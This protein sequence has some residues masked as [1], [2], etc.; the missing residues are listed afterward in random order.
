M[1]V[2]ER[3][4]SFLLGLPFHPVTMAETMAICCDMVA[5]RQPRYVITANVDFVAQAYRNP[6]LRTILQ[7]ADL[8]VCDGMPLVWLSRMFKPAL[9]ERVAGSDLVFQLFEQA[10]QHGWR[11]FFLGSDAATLEI[12]RGVLAQRYPRMRVADCF[13]PPFGPVD[14]WPNEAILQRIE[15]AQPDLLLIAVGCPKQEYWI[16]QFAKSSGVPL[17]IGIGASLDF[18]AGSQRRAPR[19]MQKTGMEWLW[20]MGTDPMRLAKRYAKDFY[21]L[22]YLSWVQWRLTR[23]ERGSAARPDGAALRSAE[24][25]R[26]PA[27][28]DYAHLE[29]IPVPEVKRGQTV[30]DLS[31]VTFM[32]SS[33]IG[34][35]VH[36]AREAR[37]V[38]VTLTLRAP[39]PVVTRLLDAMKL[40][41]LFAYEPSADRIRVLLSAGMIQKGESG[42]GRYVVELANR[43]AADPRVDLHVAGLHSDRHL[44]PAIADAAWHTI[45]AAFGGGWRNLLWHQFQLRRLLRAVGADVYH[46]PSYRRVMAACPVAQIA[47]VHDCAPFRLRD[48]YGL[49]RGL[50]GRQLVPRLV[51]RCASVITVSQFTAEDLQ[52]F[53]GLPAERISVIANGIDPEHLYP[54]DAGQ[55]AAFRKAQQLPESYFLYISRLEHPGKNHVRLLEA[56]DAYRKRGG[57]AVALVLGGADWH[58]AEVI[59]QRVAASPW[60]ADIHLVGFIKEVD[61]PL[62]YG[63]AHAMVFPSLMEGFGLPVVEAMACGVPVACSDRGSLPEVAGGA[64]LLFDPESITAMAAVMEQL[65]GLTEAQRHRRCADGLANAG[66]FHWSHAAELTASAYCRL[67]KPLMSR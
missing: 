30:L 14:Q 16:D 27:S 42:V 56:Y 64:A 28:V 35:L 31:A 34:K 44:F 36:C 10:D 62:W 13:S 7:H 12:A 24:V 61:L 67:A 19:W 55:L 20:R 29:T 33:G 32:D 50:F 51:R 40:R 43:M 2:P 11:V 38:G 17:S 39:S 60:H 47:T 5:A 6:K 66:R 53:F 54:R 15:A 25:V 65:S 18:I 4:L 59:R 1:P 9:P 3:P 52:R 22:I 8:A 37:R 58:G 45:P 63:A 23:K 26:W 48:K 41:E 21:Y 57:R 46:S 49:L